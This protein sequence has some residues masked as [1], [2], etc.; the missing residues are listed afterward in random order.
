M[1]KQMKSLNQYSLIIL[2]VLLALGIAVGGYFVGQV[3]YNAKLNTAEAKGLSERRV[4]ADLV[5]WE[6]NYGIKGNQ[7]SNIKDLYRVAEFD[8]SKIISVLKANGLDE[9]EINV[10]VINYDR[11][12][13]RNEEQVL[14]DTDHLLSGSI[15]VETE[16]VNLIPNVR[17][18]LNELLA[19][20][21]A[22]QNNRP[23]Y[24]FN[25]LNDI[26]PQMLKEATAN[27]RIAASEFAKVA[28]S[29]VRG[30][31]NARQGNFYIRDVGEDYSDD[32]KIEKEVRV[33]TTI[34]FYLEN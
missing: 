29:K 11:K 25:K 32:K 15:N 19:Q 5:H 20:G 17:T 14:V 34:S 13:Y 1:E 21:I 7:F 8:K 10:G 28:Q 24:T 16:K 33:V 3:L 6:I 2:G 26:K 22:V 27:A 4:L 23:R 9:S 18:K 12:E 31:Q 30:I